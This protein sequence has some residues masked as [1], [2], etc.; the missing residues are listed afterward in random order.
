MDPLTIWTVGHSN[1]SF[2]DF[3]ELLNSAE[4][5][6]VADVR[7]IPGSRKHPHF[8]KDQLPAALAAVGISYL[9]LP[10]LGGRRSVQPDSPNTVWRSASFQAYADHMSSNEFA[11]GLDKLLTVAA[12]SR[13]V[14]MC[15][16][17]V[18]WRCHRSLIADRI[19]ADGHQVLHLMS[20][21]K[22]PEH[23]YTSA[24][25]LVNGELSYAPKQ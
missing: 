11:S 17:A 18:W 16:E 2:E 5:E 21:G 15:S 7:R 23:P 25:S 24:A 9:H 13:V 20:P 19:K 10:E 1:R 22:H 6:L 8:G 3:K 14:I 12:E 4:I